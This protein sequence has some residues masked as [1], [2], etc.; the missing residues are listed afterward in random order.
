MSPRWTIEVR[1]AG[2]GKYR[3]ISGTDQYVVEAKAQA[4]RVEWES[5]YQ[6]ILEKE[7]DK[8]R[9]SQMKQNAKARLERE[10][11]ELQD[12]LDEA[13]ERTKEAQ[14][15]LSAVK[16]ILLS[17][18]QHETTVDWDKLKRHEPFSK[19]KP[20]P[21]RYFEYP[22][23]PQPHDARYL[24]ARSQL[25]SRPERSDPKYQVSL[26]F[27]DK[28]VKSRLEQKAQA[29][30]QAYLADYTAW[31]EKCQQV[32]TENQRLVEEL[33]ESDHSD[34]E[35]AVEKA[36]A[37]NERLY[38][39]S[40][41]EVEKWNE[42]SQEHQKEIEKENASVDERK[43]KYQS[44]QAAGVEDYNEMI[45]ANSEYP[46]I[47]PDD[48]ELG[49]TPETKILI[50]DYSLPAPQQLPRLKEVKYV[51][52]KDNFIESFISEVESNKLYDEVLYQICL[53][54][55]HELFQADT[56]NALAAI[57]FNGWVKSIDKATGNETNGC[58]LSV[59]AQVNEF[60]AIKLESVD[61]KVCFKALKGIGSSKLHSLTPVAPVL[62]I[63]RE[64]RRFVASHE[65][66]SRLNEG[67]NLAAMDWEDFEHLIRQ[68]F[69]QEFKQAGGE[70]KITQ[71][72]RDG[73]VDAVA[74]DPDVIRGGKTVIQAKRYTN[75]VGVSAVRDLYGTVLNEGASKGILVTTSDYGPDSYEFAKGK[76]LVLLSG[77]NLLNLLEKHG[78]KA[79]IDLKEA[80][81]ILGEHVR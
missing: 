38:A 32:E 17:A 45:L 13:E 1:H 35:R 61:P 20:V 28:V 31:Q 67:T 66:V 76:P 16:T 3:V 25:P 73:G 72:S 46:D 70:V 8:Q 15:A 37:K 5:R 52:S 80:K 26:T 49:Y 71:A 59:L 75:T 60:Q 12:K 11:C 42:E 27:L 74:F 57:S 56:A 34:W 24:E 68:L 18:I 44:L 36:K 63:S 6:Q 40:V 7:R 41:A 81:I 23:E 39:E 54:A 77:A 2:L 4:Q 50:V 14:E 48:F 47:F 30:E 65:I 19:P 21:P 43:A 64:D 29:V 10:K 55:L 51:K 62:T 9:Q 22:T 78:H 69:E 79:K 53:R 58:V 33:L